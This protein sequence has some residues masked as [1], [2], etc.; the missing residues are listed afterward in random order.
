MISY[1]NDESDR[2][3]RR[4]DFIVTVY[5]YPILVMAAICGVVYWA[6]I[7]NYVKDKDSMYG[8]FFSLTPALLLFAYNRRNW[9][10]MPDGTYHNLKGIPAVPKATLYEPPE[11]EAEFYYSRTQQ[12]GNLLAAL[13]MIGMSIFVFIKGKGVILLPISMNLVGLFLAYLGLKGFLDKTPK[14][15]IAKTG[16]WTS[17]LGFV[18]WDDI[19][20]ADVV[21]SKNEK[22]KRLY[23]EIRLKGTKFEQ[24]DQPDERLA[25]YELKG[26]ENVEMIITNCIEN[27]NKQ[28]KTGNS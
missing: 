6:H 24:A 28:K 27:Y 15:K 22:E 25:L 17:K 16:L 19:N 1:S 3:Q 21:E 13:G 14:L 23:L 5:L 26:R 4:K 11:Y 7:Q 12:A 8:Y 20:Y 2:S 9:I 10:K 18:K